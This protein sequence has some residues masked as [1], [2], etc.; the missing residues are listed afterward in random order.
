MTENIAPDLLGLAVPV[1]RL[2]HLDRNPR[3]GD[4]D[5]VAR[6][7]ERFGQRKPVVAR[8]DGTVIAGNHQLAAARR[9]GWSRI[10]VVWVDDDDTTAS[11]YALADNRLGDLG[12]Y[13]SEILADLIAEVRSSD[14]DLLSIAGYS[15]TDLDEI[16]SAV[17]S[18]PLEPVP[19]EPPLSAQ[20]RRIVE[21]GDV[22]RL[23]P[24]RLLCGDSRSADDVARLLD[25]AT[26]NLA[27]TSPPYADRRKYDETTAF[28][29]I[30]P[31][32]YVEWF[33][34]VAANVAAHLAD[35]G[36]WIV[37]IK[38]GSDGL[39]RDL[40]V[41]DLVIAHVREWAWHLGD[42]FCWERT[43]VPKQPRRRFKN[44]WEPVFQFARADWKFRPDNVR[45][46]SD[47]AVIPRDPGA[48]DTGW[49][50]RQD[51]PRDDLFAGQRSSRRRGAGIGTASDR[52]GVAGAVEGADLGEGFAYPGNRLPTFVGTHE[53]TGHSAAFPV[54][55]PDFFIRAYTDPGD[56]IFDPFC[57]S[58]STIL[59]A[60]Q[61]E[62]IGYGMEIS[63]AY[64]DIICARY[65]RHTGTLP[66]R[67][68]SGEPVSFI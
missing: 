17:S 68:S 42:E 32:D 56:R 67:D 18:S 13:D 48:G 27:V 37:N 6:S 21:P 2:R 10:A 51:S 4:V 28:R 30:S 66:V 43:G 34:P 24:H 3:R 50:D 58:G 12:T 54:G 33:S 52:Q 41:M 65:Q 35:D 16:L 20:T 53:A 29:P 61:T 26:I 11:A 7:Y 39:D 46:R 40:Y 49:R 55:L 38:A 44:Q 47:N 23:G 60:E 31:A 22:W 62:R 25:G 5:A 64:C 36:S 19:T 14:E 9:L 1:S 8:R 57:G 63:P 45:H 59:A 15:T